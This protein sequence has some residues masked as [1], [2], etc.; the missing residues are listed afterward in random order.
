M[1]SWEAS[2]YIHRSKDA[3]WTLGFIAVSLLSLG[4]AIWLQAWTFVAL[5]VVMA[6]AMGVFAF[7]PPHVAKYNL[8]H[9]GLEINGKLY[10]FSEFRAFGVRPEEAFFIVL[11]IPVKRFMPAIT[12][13]F[14]E[15]DGEKIVDI[16]GAHLPMEEMQPDPIDSLMRHIHF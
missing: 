2:E 14:A 13:Y 11:L 4:G 3:L 8:S 10:A 1:V 15:D 12:V 16:F 6:I 7:R 9:Q 5:I